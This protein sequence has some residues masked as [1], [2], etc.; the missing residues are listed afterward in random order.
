VLIFAGLSLVHF[1]WALGGSSGI[2]AAVPEYSGRPAFVPSA[3]ATATVA[4]GLALC[5]LLVAATAGL[6]RLPIPGHWLQWLSYALSVV[7]LARAIGDFRLVGFF[8]RVR[9]TRFAR[10]DSMVY[11]PLCLLLAA[12]VYYVA[13]VHGA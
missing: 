3:G 2:V 10:L 8:K 1:Y 12:G 7:L 6:V 11:A 4:L 9:G 13:N 5:A